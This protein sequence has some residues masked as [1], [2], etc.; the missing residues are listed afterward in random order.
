[1]RTAI[2]QRN[3]WNVLFSVAVT[4]SGRKLGARFR[5]L[6]CTR[7]TL[8]LAAQMNLSINNRRLQNPPRA[9]FA[10][11]QRSTHQD[12]EMNSGRQN[13]YI[14]RTTDEAYADYKSTP[15]RARLA[16]AGEETEAQPGSR[17]YTPSCSF[18]RGSRYSAKQA[19]SRPRNSSRMERPQKRL[20]TRI[21]L[22]QNKWR[23]GSLNETKSHRLT[24]IKEARIS[25][26]NEKETWRTNK[27][28]SIDGFR[29]LVENAH[30]GKRSPSRKRSD[31]SMTSESS[32]TGNPSREQECAPYQHQLFER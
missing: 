23:K 15:H 11:D 2:K 7:R 13:S 14:D 3:R 20:R 16:V 24:V 4:P 1:M 25:F 22:E 18:H 31:A 12:Q 30:V 10:P 26:W 27:D 32:L 19:H 5:L 21:A 8:T 6:P 17:S 29:E 28:E 9:Q